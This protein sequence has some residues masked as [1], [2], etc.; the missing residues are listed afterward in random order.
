MLF[1]MNILVLGGGNSS[2]REVSL[3]SS[4]AVRA[5]LEANGHE[6]EM[7]D[8]AQGEQAVRAGSER[9]DLIFPILHGTGGEDGTIQR[10][11]ESI[12]KPYLGSDAAASELCFDKARLKAVLAKNDILTPRG[13]VVTA[14]TF[15]TSEL[16][17]AP[18]VLK[19]VAD[20]SSVGTMIVRQLPYSRAL[21]AELLGRYGE[22]LLEE[23]IAGT[24]ITVPVLGKTALPVIEI[25]PPQGKEFDY[26]NK[27][28]G[29]TS[30]LC[31]PLHVSAKLQTRAQRLA[32]Q[33]HAASGARHISRTDMIITPDGKIY[34][35]E[36]N[37]LPGMTATSLLPRS[38][39]A[40]GMDWSALAARLVELTQS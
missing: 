8:P 23:M 1:G 28:N 27:Y 2:E 9:N 13:E 14:E 29:A 11:L 6:V 20:G 15:E 33:V 10:L 35:L 39:A 40:A 32:E 19:P 16:A 26:E 18:F 7:L 30:E 36:I 38:A 4:A 37:T 31:P 21:A 34:V 17:K 3:R 24:E 12:G 5:A 22:M 25:I